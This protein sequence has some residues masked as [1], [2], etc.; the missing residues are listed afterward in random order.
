MTEL[1]IT[2]Y[3]YWRVSQHIYRVFTAN[4]LMGEQFVEKDVEKRIIEYSKLFLKARD[5]IAKVVVGQKEMVDYLLEA[6]I[7]N[8]HV[9]LEGVPG[10]GKTLL[11][12]TISKVIGCSYSRI[13]FTPDL[14]PTDIVGVT[15]YEE[16]KGFFTVKGPIFANFVLG[17][18]IICPST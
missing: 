17:D 7:A 10:I 5:E 11:V 13:Q 12:R 8:G 15:T 14:L 3:H 4:V 2:C 18:E 6:L 16:G 9:L 1:L